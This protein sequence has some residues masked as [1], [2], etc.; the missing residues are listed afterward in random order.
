MTQPEQPQNLTPGREVIVVLGV[1]RSGTSLAMQALETLG[2]RVSEN[3]IPPNVSNPKGFYEDADI[4]AIHKHL[5]NTLTPNPSMPLREGWLNTPEAKQALAQLKVLVET[6]VET[7][8]APWAFKDPRTATFL[9]LWIRLFNQLKIVPR[10]VLAIRRPEAII[11]SFAQQYGND[12]VFAELVFLLRTL[13]TLYYTGGNCHLLPYESWFSSPQQT[14]QQLA[15][16]IFDQPTDM[17]DKAAPVSANLNRS[18][19][20]RVQ[21]N[22]PLVREL[23]EHLHACVQQPEQRDAL[24]MRVQQQREILASFKPWSTLSANQKQLNAQYREQ[25]SDAT[26][27]KKQLTACQQQLKRQTAALKQYQLAFG[28]IERLYQIT[29]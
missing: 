29:E 24:M 15:D 28:D 26:E 20:A 27:H 7:E 10:F 9:P 12:Q 13:D 2:V 16:F 3:M 22:N 5:L 8:A 23:Y 1:G 11:E 18:Q 21:V 14:L 6:Q 4:V 17:S 19:N 25:L